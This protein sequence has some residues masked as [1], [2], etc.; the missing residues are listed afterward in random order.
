M[1]IMNRS[2]SSVE[3]INDFYNLH[4]NFTV[5]LKNYL[6]SP[7][8]S[9][10]FEE[11]KSTDQK[12]FI[13]NQRSQ[14]K[15]LYEEKL[16]EKPRMKEFE[17][18]ISNNRDIKIKFIKEKDI[19]CEK[20][21]IIEDLKKQIKLLEIENDRLRKQQSFSPKSIIEPNPYEDDYPLS[22]EDSDDDIQG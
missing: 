1:Y 5:L 11:S 19:N 12:K 15:K 7:E 16:F 13:R 3:E 8:M 20:D 9:H 21:Q 4:S 10:K 14:L 6:R 18:W 2:G 22:V 17:E